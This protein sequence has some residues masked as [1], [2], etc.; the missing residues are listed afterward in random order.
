MTA[1]ARVLAYDRPMSPG[2]VRSRR[3]GDA[4]YIA[5]APDAPT[6]TALALAV[7]VLAA[8]AVLAIVGSTVL[9]GGNWWWWNVPAWLIVLGVAVLAVRHTLRQSAEPIEFTADPR[10]MRVQNRLETPPDRTVGVYEIRQLALRAHDMLAGTFVL[11][12]V[13]RDFPDRPSVVVSLLVSGSF[14]TLDKIG[15]TLAEGMG[16]QAPESDGRGGWRVV[17]EGPPGVIPSATLQQ[18]GGE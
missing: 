16:M 3:S 6:R 14:E 5:I 15:R 7:P 17:E 1:E 8:A 4:V 11:E 2:T 13:T 9:H 10:M 12:F 18:T